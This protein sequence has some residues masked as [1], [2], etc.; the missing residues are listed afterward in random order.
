MSSPISRDSAL[1][2]RRRPV[3]LERLPAGQI[4]FR[5]PA[6]EPYRYPEP[7]R[8]PYPR[9][10]S[11]DVLLRQIVPK[12]VRDPFLRQVM[13]RRYGCLRCGRTFRVY[14][15][16]I[17]PAQTSLRLRHLSLLLYLLGLSYADVPRALRAL[18]LSMSKTA[19]YLTVRAAGA[20][21]SGPRQ[22]LRAVPAEAGSGDEVAPSRWANRWLAVELGRDMWGDSI[23]RVDVFQ[24]E[25]LAALL[26]WLEQIATAADAQMLVRANRAA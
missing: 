2:I 22:R 1:G 20:A 21:V 5:F 14:P 16:G 26:P 11:R 12:A 24:T 6:L 17:G 25:D 7:V 13:A 10:G 4:A 19:V 18:G 15:Q 23:V 3:A 9:C 8:C